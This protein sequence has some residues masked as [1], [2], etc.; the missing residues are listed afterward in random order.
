MIEIRPPLRRATREDVAVVA[1]LVDIAGE[2]LPQYLWARMARPGETPWDVGERR[3]AREQG[4][5]SYRNTIVSEA[6]G[7]VV[8]CLIGY[9]LPEKPVPVDGDSVPA[10]FVPLLELENLAPASW[11]VNVLAT[12][13]GHRGRGHGARL[14]AAAERIAADVGARGLSI[15]VSDANA[16]ALRLYERCGYRRIVERTMVKESWENSGKNWVLL[17]KP[18]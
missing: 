18:I 13:P 6:D 10:L 2:G 11:Y 12:L 14:L 3:A 15:I 7:Q 16:D 5:F 4:A 9:P 1:R 8:A 17:V